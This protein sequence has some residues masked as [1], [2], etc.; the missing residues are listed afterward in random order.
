MSKPT[1]NNF[2][3]AEVMDM[4]ANA[5]RQRT[6]EI[7]HWLREREPITGLPALAITLREKYGLEK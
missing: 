6:I 7:V 5:E 2:T 1:I 4:V 3:L